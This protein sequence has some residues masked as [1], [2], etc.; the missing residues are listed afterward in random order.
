MA[1]TTQAE[2]ETL[3]E[4]LAI[5][6]AFL[7]FR[8]P[9]GGGYPRPAEVKASR[10]EISS[11]PAHAKLCAPTETECAGLLRQHGFTQP[12]VR[13]IDPKKT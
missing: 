1:I 8:A 12:V 4:K 13:R 10:A 11:D 3:I 9:H 5:A 6:T 7:R 2:R